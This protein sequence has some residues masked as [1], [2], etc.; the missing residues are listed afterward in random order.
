M[1]E[2]V[3]RIEKSDAIATLTLNRPAVYNALNSELIRA[4]IQN[5]QEIKADTSIHI[6]ILQASG[7]HFS[8]GADLKWMQ[9][10]AQTDGLKNMGELSQLMDILYHLPQITIALIQGA[11]YGGG[12]GLIA[13]CDIAIAVESAQ[14]CFSE[15]KL[16]LIP[17]VISPYIIKAIGAKAAKRYF[18]TAET[19][20]AQKAQQLGLISEVVAPADLIKHGLEMANLIANNSLQA[21]ELA[22]D[23]IDHHVDGKKI[24]NVLQKD[25]VTLITN[26]CKT[27]DA[28]QR[29]HDFFEKRKKS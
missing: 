12:I 5:L 17:A 2:P 13:C 1:T 28:Q 27:T 29:L 9:K 4:L 25:L 20:V 14:F 19:F 3:L 8:V 22:K 24:D 21:I 26:L 18:I 15:V 7:K 6:V 10:I 11:S 23:L 16:G